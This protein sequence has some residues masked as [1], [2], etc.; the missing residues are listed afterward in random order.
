MVEA[1]VDITVKHSDGYSPLHRA[2]WG[3][4]QRHTDTVE[5]FLEAGVPHDLAANGRTCVEM[6][7]NPATRK[8]LLK[9]AGQTEE[10]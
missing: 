2:C 3:S 5:V 9:W 1:H 6:T 10:L 7:H 8:L 4:D